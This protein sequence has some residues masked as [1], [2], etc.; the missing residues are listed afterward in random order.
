MMPPQ[1]KKKNNTGLDMYLTKESWV[2]ENVQNGNDDCRRCG[3]SLEN[4]SDLKRVCQKILNLKES[5][6][7]LPTS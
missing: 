5:G 6:G 2:V 3:V 1:R 4:L 7:E